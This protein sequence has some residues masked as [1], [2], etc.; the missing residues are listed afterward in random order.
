MSNVENKT[1]EI[2]DTF[3]NDSLLFTA[4]DV[5]NE[6]KKSFPLARHREVRDVVRSLFTEMEKKDYARTPIQVQLAD[7]SQVEALLY[8]NLNDSWDLSTKYDDQKRA[9]F[10]TNPVA[11]PVVP[12]P[13]PVMVPTVA[14]VS[15]V[16]VA[17]SA[18][19][20]SVASSTT[21][22]VVDPKDLW[23]NLFNGVKLFPLS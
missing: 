12:V 19:S 9:Q 11:A 1:R 14:V 16:P 4:L 3:V 2:V 20:V 17:V 22:N 23:A 5:S 8:H 21:V 18:P 15:S 10:A 6:V 7:G 13:A